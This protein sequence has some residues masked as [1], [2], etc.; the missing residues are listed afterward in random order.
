MMS[1]WKGPVWQKSFF[2]SI[3]HDDASLKQRLNQIHNHPTSKGLSPS[4]I[5]YTYSS[6]KVYEE[7]IDD[8]LTDRVSV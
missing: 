1:P 8:F 6:A 7:G 2:N 3:L 4:K 5:G